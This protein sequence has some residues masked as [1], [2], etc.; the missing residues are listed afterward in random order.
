MNFR[1]IVLRVATFLLSVLLLTTSCFG[2]YSKSYELSHGLRYTK[3]VSFDGSKRNTSFLFEYDNAESQNTRLDFVFG[4]SIYGTS[5]LGK[6]IDKALEDGENVVAGVNCDFYSI[7]T[8]VPMSAI[9]ID[10]ELLSSDDGK[11]ALGFAS[12][13]QAMIS[14]PDIKMNLRG[15]SFSYPIGHINKYPTPYS[16]YLL[17][18]KFGDTTKTDY[19]ST[20]IV[21]M[22]VNEQY[23]KEAFSLHQASQ[24]SVVFGD[25]VINE[26]LFDIPFDF[27]PYMDKRVLTAL[28][29]VKVAVTEIRYSCTDGPIPDGCFVLTADDRPYKD[30]FSKVTVG[31]VFTIDVTCDEEWQN[32]TKAIG[33]GS[34]LVKDSLAVQQPDESL[35]KSA[36]PR[37]AV[38]IKGDGSIVFYCV[39]GRK[40][41]YSSGMTADE[42]I[43]TLIKLGCT[44]AMNLD[45]G[46]SVTAYAMFPGIGTAERVNRPSDGF[47]RAVSN[48][49]VFVNTLEPTGNISGAYLP[50]EDFYVLGGGSKVSLGET[51]Y[52]YDDAFYPC[53]ELAVAQANLRGDGVTGYVEDGVFISG[54]AEGKC[55]VSYCSVPDCVSPCTHTVFSVAEIYVTNS[56]D[57]FS[58][59]SSENKVYENQ[60]VGLKASA[61]KDMLP[62][63]LDFDKLWCGVNG[64][65]VKP[66][67]YEDEDCII[68]PDG[69]L[70]LKEQGC[71]DTLDITFTAGNSICNFTV[72]A[73]RPA[74]TDMQGHWAEEAANLAA[75]I[76]I[77]NGM[78][79][80]ER[81]GKFI[82][83]PDRT[84]KT[85]EFCA[86]LARYL[87]LPLSESDACDIR[88]DY[89]DSE[90]WAVPYVLSLVDNGIVTPLMEYDE[91][92]LAY[93]DL[94]SEILRIDAMRVL[95]ALVEK[96]A[97][98][99]EDSSHLSEKASALYCDLEEYLQDDYRDNISR[100]VS[101]GLF[102]G[103]P[104]MTMRPQNPVT[105]AQMASLFVRLAGFMNE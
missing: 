57:S 85:A 59:V 25:Y 65:A 42:L 44:D 97:G 39:D 67:P 19:P 10:G 95:G 49:A 26:S 18:D 88:L 14:Y 77:V 96:T 7:K 27:S 94:S 75:D 104:D 56:P 41:G 98:G 28:C 40:P 51:L 84:V 76:G 37:T 105:R 103:Y 2:I 92:M 34:I 93:I 55:V 54:N 89:T 78:A 87:E 17:T 13:G 38:G 9:I 16:V 21:L 53:G 79:D 23:S 81:Q 46:G 100:A 73:V 30:I 99:D 74:F 91:N 80:P 82:F 102:S 63:R 47:E 15:E 72:K 8:G 3:T 50:C 11:P 101:S 90:S 52:L 64:S 32:V 62:V 66:L 5:T 1:N 68:S 86:M 31:D 71:A 83:R 61:V 24:P 4:D 22:P 48:C 69:L 12:D 35:Y 70:T 29:S 43:S 20:E 60:S 33:G 45:G 36:N 58:V 6:M